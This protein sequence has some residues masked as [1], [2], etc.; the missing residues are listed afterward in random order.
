MFDVKN[1]K[2][3]YLIV[4]RKIRS[5]LQNNGREF[6]IFLFFLF[7]SFGF[8][9]LQT[10]NDVYQT[11]FNIKTRLR[12]IPDNVVLTREFPDEVKVKVEDRGTVLLNYLLARSF[13]PVSFDFKDY[14]NADNHAYITQ[15]VIREKIASQLN[16]TTRLLSVLPDTLEVVYSKGNM[17]KV[18]VVLNG[19][20]TPER[21][22]Y[23]SDVSFNPDSVL[24]YAP[25]DVLSS[26]TAVY[27]EPLD[28]AKVADT[29]LVTAPLQKIE[30]AK[31]VPDNSELTIHAEMYAEKILEVP[32]VGVGF[33]DNK[34]LRTFPSKAK[35]IFQVSLKR[36]KDV[37]PN[38]FRIEVN[39]ADL[40]GGSTDKVRLVVKESPSFVSRIRVN[41]ESVD[42]LIEQRYIETTEIND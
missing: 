8:W 12:G 6:L 3:I 25:D 38:D 16:T 28:Y 10:M 18:P 42:Y 34:I 23:I 4:L 31:F 20:I 19:A 39:Y 41:P 7:V 32:I 37:L 9:L 24:I 30:N 35:V 17:K 15:R 14:V 5:S 13:L 1:I 11:D 27:T 33:P 22:Y 36:F 29:L 2:R 40:I 21:M 26:I